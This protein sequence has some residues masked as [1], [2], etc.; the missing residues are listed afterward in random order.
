MNKNLKTIIKLG[1]LRFLAGG[2]FL[3]TM[4]V[5]LAITSGVEFSFLYFIF[6][7]A[8]MLPAHLSLS[9]SNNY[10]D[11]EVDKF[12]KP[13][14]ISGGTKILIEN[15]E[16]RPLC[17]TIALGL[18]VLSIFIALIFMFLFSFP[19]TFLGFIIFGNLLG[20][21]YTA[22]PIRLAYRGLGEIANMINM[23][24]LMPGIGYWAISGNL[25]LFFLIFA[26]A[27]LIYG[28]NFMII[29]ETPDMEGDK[30]AK[31]IT[32]VTKIGRKN[33][34]K[35]TIICLFCASLYFLMIAYLGLF[36]TQI[37]YYI[38]FLLSLIPLIIAIYGWLKKPFSINSAS[39][40]AQ[41][42]MY[43]LLFLIF[44]I[45]IYL[46]IISYM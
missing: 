43:A 17:K 28:L 3:Y 36:N 41:N 33:S 45:N 27:F 32:L 6:G 15:P 21:F 29:V 31:K 11:I 20:W 40:I 18:I 10:F 14:S 12:N 42:N 39:K 37:D 16:L 35:I 44:S 4:G 38:I 25:D 30:K 9:Y 5:L 24:F 22:P 7:Y 23:G 26:I 19:I 34:Y 13:I 8:I 46:L 2:F 1:R